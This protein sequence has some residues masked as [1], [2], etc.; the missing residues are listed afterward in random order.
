MEENYYYLPDEKY[1]DDPFFRI[2]FRGQDLDKYIL[3][4]YIL[5][6]NYY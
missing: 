4:Y 1:E 6:E 3:Y 5:P 2:A